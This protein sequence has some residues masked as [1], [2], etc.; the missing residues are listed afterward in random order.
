MRPCN[1]LIRLSNT[2]FKYRPKLLCIYLVE[3]I[4]T[5]IFAGLLAPS[6]FYIFSSPVMLPYKT[7]IPIQREADSPL[8]LQI[9]NALAKE[10]KKGIIPAGT[11]L[12]GTRA[13]AQ[14]LQ[15]HR[16]T[17][18]AAFDELYAQGWI[19]TIPSKGT[20]VSRALPEVSPKPL[21]KEH[22]ESPSTLPKQTGYVLYPNI[23][24]NKTV[25]VNKGTLAFTDGF[26]DSRLAPIQALHRTYRAILKRGVSRHLL[27]YHEIGGNPSLR[28]ALS[29]YLNQSRGLHTGPEN[30][31]IT[32]GSQMAIY[33]VAQVLLSPG[34]RVVIGETNYNAAN[35]AFEY[36]GAT[37][38][39]IPVDDFGLEVDHIDEICQQKAIRAVF[40]TSHHHHPTTVTLRAD[41]RIKLLK[42]AEKYRFAIIEDDYDYD[43]HYQSSPILPLASADTYGLVIYI[44]S[45]T[46][47]LT[48]AI[49]VGYIAAPENFIDEAISL[50]RIVDRQGD[51]LMEQAVAEL[52]R[53]GEVKS[54]VKKAVKA[55]KERRDI[56]C[57]LLQEKL[58]DVITFRVP[59]GGMAVWAQFD[60]AVLLPE[61]SRKA[62]LKG[63]YL[64]DGS[65][66]NPPGKLLNATRMGF[67][68]LNPEEIGESVAIL[69]RIIR[70]G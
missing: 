70:G 16:K 18:V 41:R 9:A 49:R 28:A 26:P 15:V 30:F 64:P 21:E 54:H 20:F 34:D 67:A 33:L 61:I 4:Q 63:L 31:M 45:L 27:S 24:L 14:L 7:I 57:S 51:P 3:L 12:P 50:R 5:Y 52:L 40:V 68:S 17:V 29:Q 60:P 42:L 59:D 43:F 58:S 1:S 46:K 35:M 25:F 10:I 56:F 36:A 66:Y 38:V 48:P 53:D 22:K 2:C 55:Y 23:N 69:E 39:R 65:V 19:E 8:S 62:G 13:L 11:K 44:G 37:L 32:R 6:A 47:T